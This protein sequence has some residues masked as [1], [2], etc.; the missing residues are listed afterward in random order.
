MLCFMDGT[1][2]YSKDVYQLIQDLNKGLERAVNYL[3]TVYY[4]RLCRFA[5]TIVESPEVAEDIVQEVFIRIWERKLKISSQISLDS[6]LFVAVRNSC[7][8][9]HRKEKSTVGLEKVMYQAEETQ[10]CDLTNIWDAINSLPIQCREVLVL[11]V[12]ENMK[13]SEA[14]EKLGIS[15]NTVK[16]QMRIS[17]RELR[18]KLSKD[19]LFCCV[20]FFYQIIKK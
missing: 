7:I 14:A 16:T 9:F 1:I 12:F 18:K 17:Y 11:V 19:E 8:S 13:Y 20:S 4:V 5:R 6:Y 3:F 15:I 10:V 2:D